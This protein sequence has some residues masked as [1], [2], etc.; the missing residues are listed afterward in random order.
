[1]K[2]KR[3]LLSIL[4]VMAVLCVLPEASCDSPGYPPGYFDNPAW[5][6]GKAELCVYEATVEKYRRP[7]TASVK[8]ILVKERFCADKLVKT[9]AEE[10]SFEVIKFHSIQ[11]VPTGIYDYFQTKSI[12][13][14][15]G[16]GRV[17]KYTMSSQDGCG[18]TFMEFLARGRKGT[19]L[20]HSYW[21]D[22]GDRALELDITDE[23]F[24]DALPVTLRTRLTEGLDERISLIPG[25]VSNKMVAPSPFEARLTMV[26]RAGSDMG[27]P[28]R[29][30]L[31]EVTVV[32]GTAKEV[33][34]FDA[35]FPNRLVRWERADGDRLELKKAYNIDYWNYTGDEHRAL[36]E[37]E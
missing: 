2:K 9:A 37:P 20:F 11:K 5:D 16:T 19:F 13:F 22:Q 29:K 8:M 23:V 35:A 14:D 3:L 28:D 26:K 21:D 30:E 36:Q 7:R 15:R 27:L 25:L 12:F 34:L 4:A 24:Y 10:E 1:M 31:F 32:T 33:L 17:V 6:N 18:N